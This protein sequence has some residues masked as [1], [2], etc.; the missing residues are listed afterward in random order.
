[1]IFQ[2]YALYP[3]MT[4][5]QNMGFGLK[6]RRFPKAETDRR[7]REAAETLG[8]TEYLNRKPKALS[9]GQRQ[10]VAVGRAI[11]REPAV[12]L[13]DEPLS[14][15]D[16]QMRVEMRSEIRKLHREL[17][18]TMIYVTHDQVEALTMGDRIV[19]MD[20]GRVQ[21]IADPK[22]LYEKPRNRFVGG[23]IGSPPMNFF[24]GR[25][26]S[27]GDALFFD[28]GTFKLRVP[29][30]HAEKLRDYGPLEI[31][32]GIRPE[33]LR[34]QA[35]AGATESITA[36]VENREPL[37]AEMMV[38]LTTGRTSFVARLGA[39]ATGEIGK[40]KTLYPKTAKGHF[41]HIQTEER[42]D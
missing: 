26:T 28:E 17:K 31:V 35:S 2:N 19:V 22:T 30:A 41:F 27:K 5:Y 11:V 23:F 24:E 1:M 29:A 7:V 20:E 37:G 14:N 38:Y 6:M 12:F 42:I 36:E 39:D 40:P 3:H 21:Q 32:F 13:F 16:A 33:E 8:L 25:L 18:T 34:E 10:R 9:G 4:V 15:L